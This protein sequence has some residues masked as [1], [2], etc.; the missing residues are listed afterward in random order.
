MELYKDSSK[1]VKE[2]VEDLLSRMTLQEKVGQLNQRL[3]GFMAY[4]REGEEI[5]L[6]PE[7]IRECETF[8]GLGV[9]Y[10]LYRADPWSAKTTE[11]GLVGKL[12]PKA[13]NLLQKCVLEHSRLGIPMLLSSECP[14]G[15]QALGGYLLPVNLAVGATFHPELLEEAGAVCGAQLKEMGVNLALVSA[16][17]VLRDPRW[18]RSEECYSEDP[19]LS[20]QFA[21][22]AVRGIQKKVP[23][24][25]KHFC[26]QGEGT[27]GVNASAARIGERELREIHLPAAK[28][29]VDAGVRGIMAAYN[30][31]D[32]VY[33]HVNKKLLTDILRDEFGFDGIVMADGMALNRLREMTGD[34]VLSSALA[35]KA[36][37]DVS[38]W[39]NVFPQLEKA[40]QQGMVDMEVLDEAVRR[41]LTLKF[42]Q[43]L[44]E[45]PYLPETDDWDHY[46]MEAYPQSLQLAK[47]SAVLL[48]NE[49]QVLP[50][51]GEGKTI[52][53]LG[54]N[55]ED[56][57][58]QLG[59]YTP[60]VGDAES[61]TVSRGMQH[62]AGS[63]R[64]L[65]MPYGEL[66]AQRKQEL[67]AICQQA[68]VIVL[69]LGGSSSR[70]EGAAF[71]DNGAALLSEH[72]AMEC[73]EGLDAAK[74]ELPGDQV[75]WV[76][77]AKASGKA[78]VSVVIQGRPYA[79]PEVAALSDAVLSCFY[80]GPAGGLAIA[81]L[82]Y[83]QESPS[84]RLPVSVPAHV[85]QVPVYYNPKKSYD[86][87]HYCDM[88]DKPLYGFGQGFG[89]GKITYQPME[90]TIDR[91][92]TRVLVS[93]TAAN[94]G[95]LADWAVP[96]LYI[97]DVQAS[98]VR[99][100]REL[101]AFDKKKLLPGERH[102]FTLVLEQ[103]TFCVWDLS[104]EYTLEHGEVE[105]FLADSG[106]D[107]DHTVI[108]V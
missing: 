95:A 7:T 8:C 100:V 67:D 51:T 44:F 49:N 58:R 57:Y 22:A 93:V 47:E 90:I 35:L 72:L 85:G 64:I 107:W 15:H 98:T 52:A 40:V 104:M 11:T 69:V 66:N 5:R 1:T 80:P 106:I 34:D 87:M 60:P 9:V 99:R 10:G 23:M 29:C 36:G 17:D 76:K 13:Y 75:D 14:H 83:G 45:H 12:A 73:G 28:A 4:E 97:H 65:T 2:R 77:A 19:Y 88:T 74:L 78:V 43:G 68:D 61:W 31:I 3:Y 24:V 6:T 89:Y 108:H 84:G 16:L 96:Q 63:H 39:D 30:E 26:A 33:C 79:I 102:T 18:G 59:D 54:P 38:L 56:I 27:G 71:D 81:Q 37:V 105:L 62:L 25:A 50:I 48:K 103:D 46:T 55:T 92:N 53:V 86:R 21:K 94:E 82:L 101:K 42:E 91:E 32:G 41:V 70:F 20:S